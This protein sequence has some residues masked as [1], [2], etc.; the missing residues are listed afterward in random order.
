MMKSKSKIISS[1]NGTDKRKKCLSCG[2]LLDKRKRR[3]CS[4]ECKDRLV[5]ALRWLKNLLLALNTNYATFSF[6]EYLL[7][8]NILPHRSKEVFSYFYKRTPG[9]TP[10]E[11][12]KAMCLELS[13]E[14]YNKNEQ[15]NCRALAS[16]HILKKGQKGVVSKDLIEPVA[17]KSKYNIQKQ[18]KSLKLSID[19]MD[20]EGSKEKIK[21]AYRKEAMRTHPDV[22]G[23]GEKF[24]I[25]SESYQELIQWLKIPVFIIARGVPDKW[26]YDGTSYKWRTPL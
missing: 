19:D 13:R 23:D 2:V 17:K 6:S 26:S 25:V 20:S 9:Q 15:T 22:G 24:K 5:F 14:W 4:K 18:L 7:I 10:A 21:A 3:Y 8:V 16:V 1:A 12:L 11:D